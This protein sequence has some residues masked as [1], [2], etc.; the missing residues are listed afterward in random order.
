MGRDHFG[1]EAVGRVARQQ[2]S[3]AAE[4]T[5]IA[6]I[7]EEGLVHLDGVG[8]ETDPRHARGTDAKNAVQLDAHAHGFVLDLER[9]CLP[10]E[11]NRS[12]SSACQPGQHGTRRSL[13]CENARFIAVELDRKIV[14]PPAA[15][16]D[17]R[18]V[19]FAHEGVMLGKQVSEIRQSRRHR[20]W[21]MRVPLLALSL[22]IDG[23]RIGEQGV[24][25]KLVFA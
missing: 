15:F 14:R 8:G 6:G 1:G 17:A 24:E 13:V 3:A 20:V 4:E 10:P 16:C 18:A 23:P 12:I 7:T 2:W 25:G 22:A 19:S 9:A 5:A 11:R 21:K